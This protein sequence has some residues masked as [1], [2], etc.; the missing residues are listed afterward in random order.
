MRRYEFFSDLQYID[1]LPRKHP[2]KNISR[3][4]FTIFVIRTQK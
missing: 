4:I 1:P 3:N 2:E